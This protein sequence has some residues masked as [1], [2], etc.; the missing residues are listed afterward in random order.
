MVDDLISI[1][2]SCYRAFES[3][4]AWL[5]NIADTTS[6]ALGFGVAAY[7]FDPSDP[8]QLRIS[9]FATARTPLEEQP[10]VGL[11]TGLPPPLVVRV[12]LADAPV[13]LLSECIGERVLGPVAWRDARPAW[14][15]LQAAGTLDS[16]GICAA[17][18]SGDGCRL[19]LLLSRS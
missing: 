6:A 11:T 15:A 14:S 12:F 8:Q 5:K 3:D 16:I 4:R 9:D 10:V 13:K 1:V 19:S 18:P 7:A 2:E 17:E